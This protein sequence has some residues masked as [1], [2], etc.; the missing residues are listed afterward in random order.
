[1]TFLGHVVSDKGVKVDPRNTEA[2]KKWPKP[3]TPIDIR[4]FFGLPCYYRRFVEDFS[5]IA[6]SLTTLTKK[7]A[8]F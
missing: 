7:K 8:K 2:V 6:F 4:R 3:L 5:T 1:M